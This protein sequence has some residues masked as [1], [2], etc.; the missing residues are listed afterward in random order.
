MEI[1]T[2]LAC[3]SPLLTTTSLGQLSIIAQAIFSMTGRVTM[4]GISRWTEDGG[5]YRT[6]QRFFATELPWLDLLVKFVETHL[7]E[8]SHEY[9]LAGDATTVT[10]SGSITHGIGRFFSGV[11]GCVVKSLE[12]FVFSLVDVTRRTAYPLCVKQ[13]VRSKAEKVTKKPRKK[14]RKSKK[15]EPSKKLKGRP[16]GVLNKNKNELN[17]SAELLRINELLSKLLKILRVFVKVKYLALDGHFGHNQAV[18]MALENDLHLISKLRRDSPLFEKYEGK[19]KPK[20]P[21]R[22]YGEQLHYEAMPIKYL[23]KTEVEGQIIVNYYQGVFLHKS[24]GM[25]LNVV[26]IVK[27]DLKKRKVGYVI[28]FSSDEEL[29]WEKLIEYYSLRFQIEFNF[30]DAKQHFGLE[31]FMNTT[32]RGVE[33]AVNLSFLM[34]N[35]SAKL[36]KNS[37]EKVT[38]INDLKTH[39]RGAKYARWIIKKVLKNAE[40]ILNKEILAEIGRLGSIHQAKAA[41]SSA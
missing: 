27:T 40:P 7:F 14:A 37:E 33:N 25:P 4:R 23:K 26:V 3:C 13:T 10:K 15:K 36:L 34:V 22:K 38:G 18:L 24:F 8:A 39:Y 9:I 6:V 29:G 41:V 1:L 5:S 31:D 2:L 28:L 30:R 19:Q 17:L 32:Q 11:L 12:F 20:G 21:R 35:V 16:K